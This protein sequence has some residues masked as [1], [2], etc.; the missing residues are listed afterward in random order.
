MSLRSDS[1]DTQ[2]LTS[3]GKKL[4]MHIA[5]FSPRFISLGDVPQSLAA[6]LGQIV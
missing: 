6:Q 4:A 2:G 3:L 1:K 5:G